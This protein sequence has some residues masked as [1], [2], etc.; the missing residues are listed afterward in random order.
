[1]TAGRRPPTGLARQ[2]SRRGGPCSASRRSSR[3]LESEPPLGD[4]SRNWNCVHSIT[5]V[6]GRRAQK[7]PPATGRGLRLRRWRPVDNDRLAQRDD[8]REELKALGEVPGADLPR[9]RRRRPVR[10]PGNQSVTR[11]ACVSRDRGRRADQVQAVP[12]PGPR[13]SRARQRRRTGYG[14]GTLV[15]DRA[16]RPRRT[17][18]RSPRPGWRREPATG[19]QSPPASG[20]ATAIQKVRIVKPISSI[21]TTVDSVKLVATPVSFTA[22]GTNSRNDSDCL[23]TYS[24]V[25]DGQ[26]RDLRDREH[27]REVVEELEHHPDTG[28]S[29]SPATLRARPRPAWARPP[30]MHKVRTAAT[31]A[32]TVA[33]V[34]RVELAKRPFRVGY[35]SRSVRTRRRLLTQGSPQGPGR[36]RLVPSRR[37]SSTQALTFSTAWRPEL[38]GDAE[39]D[40]SYGSTRLGWHHL[41]KLS[42]YSCLLLDAA[43]AT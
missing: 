8:L 12:R 23:D 21:R 25:C 18:G 3:I 34:G 42:P 32:G 40:A 20:I 26:S 38:E 22:R 2:R 10:Q 16:E 5:A 28:C 39:H 43:A 15:C 4:Y 27:E 29:V 36:G 9:Q 14:S 33:D 6:A 1:M 30:R 41:Q 31:Y 7:P 19:P 35:P 24:S 11:G 37:S 13:R 17:S